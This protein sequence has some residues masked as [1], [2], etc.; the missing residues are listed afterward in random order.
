MLRPSSLSLPRPF[1]SEI[2]YAFPPYFVPPADER[3]RIG[4]EVDI[5]L[6]IKPRNISG[7]LLAVHSSRDYLKLEMIDG[8]VNFTVDNGNGAVST[9]FKPPSSSYFCDGHWHSVTGKLRIR[10]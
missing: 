7:L 2:E 5:K 4:K 3:F 8:S 9:V 1:S 6:E 10:F